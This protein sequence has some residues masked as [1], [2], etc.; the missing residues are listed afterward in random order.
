MIYKTDAIF[1]FFFWFYVH[2]LLCILR[3]F[4]GKSFIIIHF[5]VYAT[6]AQRSFDV[7]CS[8]WLIVECTL[9]YRLFDA[10]DFRKN[11]KKIVRFTTLTLY[12]LSCS[13]YRLYIHQYK[14]WKNRN[15]PLL[16]ADTNIYTAANNNVCVR[17]DD[18]FFKNIFRQI[19]KHLHRIILGE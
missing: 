5:I 15:M 1:Y 3:P 19:S 14:K 13:E 11:N 7:L 2:C 9:K 6:Y 17:A 10:V 16:T 8:G 4:L 18:D 12:F